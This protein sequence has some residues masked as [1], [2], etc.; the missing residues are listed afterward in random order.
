MKAASIRIYRKPPGSSGAAHRQGRN[1][2]VG[3]LAC[4]RGGKNR[5]P[6]VIGAREG[7]REHPPHQSS[8]IGCCAVDLA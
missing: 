6:D 2:L 3:F 5:V 4:H 7:P 8:L 1:A